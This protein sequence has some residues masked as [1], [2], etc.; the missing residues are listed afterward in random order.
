MEAIGRFREK[1]QPEVQISFWMLIQQIKY[2]G[3][4]RGVEI[5]S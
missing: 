5:L 4:E 2:K 3:D 1:E